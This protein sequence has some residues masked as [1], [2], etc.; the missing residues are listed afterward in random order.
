MNGLY[1]NLTA[2]FDNTEFRSNFAT[3]GAGM[4]NLF[5]KIAATDCR[6]G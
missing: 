6:V 5:G 3:D 1:G 2:S 4:A